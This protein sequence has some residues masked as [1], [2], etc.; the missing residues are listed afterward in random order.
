M[1]PIRLFLSAVA[2]AAFTTPALSEQDTTCMSPLAHS[3]CAYEAI[4]AH[5]TDTYKRTGGGG[6]GGIRQISTDVYEV[7]ILHEGG[8]NVMTVAV[9]HAE[10]GTVTRVTEE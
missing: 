7:K 4:L 9:T 10:D 8:P 6:I 2:V 5:L 1:K 3:I